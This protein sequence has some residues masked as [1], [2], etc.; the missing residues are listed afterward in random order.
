ML[1]PQTQK[2]LQLLRE[3]YANTAAFVADLL[4]DRLLQKHAR[5]ICHFLQPLH[6][7]YVNDLNC[8]A[9]GQTKVLYWHGDRC[10]GSCY[11]VTV[12]RMF[13]LLQDTSVVGLLDLRPQPLLGGHALDGSNPVIADDKKLV[14]RCFQFVVELAA[15]RCWSQSF[16]T[17]LF[18]FAI[19]GLYA[20][21][22]SDRRRCQCVCNNLA[23]ALIKLEDLIKKAPNN[24]D[25][26]GLRNSLGTADWPLV[27]EILVLGHQKKWNPDS[28]DLRQLVFKLFAGPGST[29]DALESCFNWLKD[30]VKV[31]KSKRMNDFT[32]FF[33]VL[34]NPYV[35]HAG[36]DQIRP[37][38]QD[39]RDFLD[40][41]F[42]DEEVTQHHLF[43]YRR[44][45][46]GQTFPRP[47]QLIADAKVRKA[48]FHS[49][50]IAASAA[51]FMLHDAPHGFTH[52]GD[53][54]PGT[55]INMYVCIYIYIWTY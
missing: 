2:Q 50:R 9:D 43:A 23:T 1:D 47:N 17:I 25:L 8:H 12:V 30:S 27:R 22:T 19:A 20:T 5:L 13:Q 33:Y 15:N 51:A 48:G 40:E 18:P 49:N 46:L 29:K 52:A 35:R 10:C 24:A 45:Q 44:T 41:H 39:F 38:L 6:A 14:Q 55:A 34:A 42:K 26:K 4:G 54:W 21:E 31:S 37:T 53:C 28:D 11:K 32:K 16:W 7:E 36:V 3:S